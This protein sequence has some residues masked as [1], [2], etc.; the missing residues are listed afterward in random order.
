[1]K[2][3]RFERKGDTRGGTRGKRAKSALPS[4]Q[5]GRLPE[6]LFV[7]L[8]SELI[9]FIELISPLPKQGT[10]RIYFHLF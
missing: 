8:P 5:V 4:A 2:R 10:F 1:M 3:E 6:L 9:L 7:A